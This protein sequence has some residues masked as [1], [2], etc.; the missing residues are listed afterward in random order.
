MGLKV[1]TVEVRF[2]GL[3]I[4]ANVQIGHRALPT[5]INYTRDTLEVEKK[6]TIFFF[7]H[8]SLSLY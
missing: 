7:F 2:E 8:F 3:N 4:S 5:L 6:L 1:P